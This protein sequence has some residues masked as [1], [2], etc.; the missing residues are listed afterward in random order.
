MK[1]T[2]EKKPFGKKLLKATLIPLAF[3]VVLVIIV[4]IALNSEESPKSR[5]PTQSKSE[6][7]PSSKADTAKTSSS[8]TQEKTETKTLT[9]KEFNEI[10]EEC[11]DSETNQL[12][13]CYSSLAIKYKNSNFC[14]QITKSYQWTRDPALTARYK[15]EDEW[16]IFAII[17]Y[18]F[19][20]YARYK[21]ATK[22]SSVVSICQNYNGKYL[23]K[24]CNS[25][26]F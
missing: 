12:I 10:A 22:D 18:I 23:N 6:M 25:R 1:D 14:E 24:E 13:A 2:T 4:N 26:L 15:V 11:Y 19:V 9:E 8:P 7:T 20:C 3:V 17:D 5:E 16:V 21:E